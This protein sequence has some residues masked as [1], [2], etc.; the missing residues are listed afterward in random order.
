MQTSVQEERVFVLLPQNHPFCVPA[1]LPLCSPSW[2]DISLTK[3]GRSRFYHT[4]TVPALFSA[5]VKGVS[6]LEL[7]G[8]LLTAFSILMMLVQITDRGLADISK[9]PVSSC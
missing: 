3:D 1:L 5:M 7:S 8:D 2:Q 6:P 4:D 9:T